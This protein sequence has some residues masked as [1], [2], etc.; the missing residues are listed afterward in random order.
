MA[1]IYQISIKGRTIR[2][3][4][5]E[6]K[7]FRMDCLNLVGKFITEK[8]INF[9]TCKNALVGMWENPEGVFISE[10]SKNKILI[11]FKNQ[12]KGLQILKNGSWSFRGQLLNLK[13]WTQNMAIEEVEHNFIEFWVQI[14]GLPLEF[15][16]KETAKKIGDMMGNVK[17]VED[18]MKDNI[19]VKNFLRVRVALNV[20]EALPT[21]F[22]LERDNLPN[23]WIFFK[24]DTGSK[25]EER[26]DQEVEEEARKFHEEGRRVVGQQESVDNEKE[27]SLM[28]KHKQL[29]KEIGGIL[30]SKVQ[31]D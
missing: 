8:E 26:M 15:I 13:V 20:T 4:Q 17:K 9:R 5:E 1:G 2:F 28:E 10:V 21:G 25:S 7:G 23:C 27:D 30:R 24:E 19:L 29:G 6:H 12:R 11:S 22:W 14:H 16:N 18:P 3:K 31:E